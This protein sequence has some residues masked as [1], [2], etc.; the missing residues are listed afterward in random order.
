[1][2]DPFV[3]MNF[4]FPAKSH[5]ELRADRPMSELPRAPGYPKPVFESRLRKHDPNWSWFLCT[6][7]GPHSH[8]RI[9]SQRSPQ[10]TRPIAHCSRSCCLLHLNPSRSVLP[11]SAS[12]GVSQQPARRPRLPTTLETGL[13]R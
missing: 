11:Q 4:D 3:G 12:M 9:G 8:A 7:D 2:N 13:N 6:A 5:A 10:G 1:L